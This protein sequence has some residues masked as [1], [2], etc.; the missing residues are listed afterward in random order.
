MGGLDPGRAEPWAMLDPGTVWTPGGQEPVPD[1]TRGTAYTRL[2][3]GPGWTRGGQ[4]TEPRWILSSLDPERT[5]PS[6]DKEL[7]P[8]GPGTR[9]DSREQD[10]GRT[11]VWAR[12]DPGRSG[13]QTR[14]DLDQARIT[15]GQSLTS[16]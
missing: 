12:L 4:N 13:P 7:S 15:E 2:D 5:G 6:E 9:E 11:G 1:R 14:Q 8:A 3:P 16:P 10:P